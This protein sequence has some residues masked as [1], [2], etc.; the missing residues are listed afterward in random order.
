MIVRHLSLTNF[1]N[2]I[3]LEADFPTGP[4]LLVGDNAQGK[5]SLL[6][7]IH[8]LTAASSPHA[9]SDR[10]LINFR[11]LREPQPFARIVAEVSAANEIK[12]I[13]I[14]LIDEP[15]G[16]GEFR[17]KKEVFVNGLRRKVADLAG[18]FN[19]VLFLPQEMQVIEGSPSARRRYLD[20]ALSQVDRAYAE[21]LSEYGKVL[22]QRNALLK[23]LQEHG[24]DAGQLDFWDEQLVGHG[25]AL[26]QARAVALDEL[27][28]LAAPIHRALTRSAETLRL[29]Y[30]PSY[31]PAAPGGGQIELPMDIPVERGGIPL[32]QI[33]AG[34]LRRLQENRSEEIARGVT[35][36]GPHR[37]EARFIASGLD[38]GTYGSRGQV[39]TALLSL[40]LAELEWMRAKVG[41][42]PVLLLD[43][44]LAELD[45]ERRADLLARINGA[46]QA[47]MTTTDADLFTTDFKQRAQVWR[48]EAGTV[49]ENDE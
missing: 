20:E 21:A 33:R 36:S 4:L 27:E 26:I 7:A 16:A 25:A 9:A 49:E 19:A 3:R 31:D 44:I 28:R 46:E 40:K 38:L 6:E 29:V 47:V 12:R 23:R 11:A 37:D 35:L 32:D 43:E 39:R 41:E 30:R 1:R 10:Q 15:V 8:Y 13:E 45:A 2:Y 24:G 14:R 17:F 34:L 5:T 22:S 18:Q 42:W 48:V